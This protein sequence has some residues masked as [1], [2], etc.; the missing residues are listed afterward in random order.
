[1]SRSVNKRVTRMNVD[2]NSPL[3]RTGDI[4]VVSE[5]HANITHDESDNKLG[6]HNII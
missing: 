3:A 4:S 2:I 1:M 5:K 6:S